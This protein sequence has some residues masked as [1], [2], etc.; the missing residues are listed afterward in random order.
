MPP[1]AETVHRLRGQVAEEAEMITREQ[2]LTSMRHEVKVIQHLATKVP[3][4]AL[5]WRPTPG[6]RSTLELLRYLTI[7]AIVPVRAMIAG[8][9]DHDEAYETASQSVTPELF[10][11]AMEKQ[12]H[13]IDHAIAAIPEADFLAKDATMPWG[14]PAKLGMALIDCG[15]KPLVAYRMQLFLYAKQSADPALGPANCWVGVDAPK[16]AAAK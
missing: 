6:Q 8:D 10:P 9:W 7:A 14:T 12:M 4:T 5:D 3:K 15:L 16:P 1:R 2:L 11:S 13:E